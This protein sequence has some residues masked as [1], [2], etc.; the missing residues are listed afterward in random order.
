MTVKVLI[1][2]LGSKFNT[3]GGQARLAAVLSKRLSR[4]FKTYYLG[5]RTS[6]S[7]GIRHHIFIERD[8]K[9]GLSI[10]KSGLSEMWGPRFAYNLLVVSRMS[11]LDKESLLE[12]A[13]DIGPSVII[14]NSI[15]DIN[16]L[17]FFRKRGLNFKAIYIDHGSVSTSIRGYFSKEGIPLTVGTGFDSL[18]LYRKKTK[19]FN[20]YDITVAL[21]HD[22]LGRICDFTDKVALIQ[23][24]LDIKPA[25][26]RS[27]AQRIRAAHGIRVK[28]FVVLYI[29]RMFDRQKNVSALI[30]AFRGINDSNLKLLLV[31]D[32]P[33]LESYRQLASGDDRIIFWGGADDKDVGSIYGMSDLF[34]LPSF[35]EGFSLTILEAAAHGLPMILSSNAYI[36]D[37]KG[38]GMDEIA[39]FDPNSPD[40]LRNCIVDMYTNRA[41]RARAI[42]ASV[43]ISRKF[44]ES[45]MVEKYRDLILKLA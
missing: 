36:D 34:V 7:D 33:S 26:D 2:D 18:S 27:K 32:G 5:Y 10:R 41:R 8:K 9:L 15:Q 29:G 44:T 6:Y 3:V 30:R 19:F 4:Y 38:G 22:Q 13:R 28:D 17:R 21:N 43:K 1:V 39:S 40:E 42:R 14:A 25:K 16:L 37:L 24:G 45:M 31:G 35:W 11:D 12:K 20:F 23:N